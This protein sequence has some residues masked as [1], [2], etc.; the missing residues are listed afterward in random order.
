MRTPCIDHGKK[1][2]TN[3]YL[4]RK[5]GGRNEYA[6]RWAYSL[7]TGVPIRALRGV[8]IRHTCDNARCIN[9]DHLVRGTHLDN[10]LD[11]VER[12]RNPKLPR[13]FTEAQRDAIRLRYQRGH[14]HNGMSAMARE[15]KASTAT[16]WRIIHGT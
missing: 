15:F 12:K 3:G 16:M 10:V 13:V 6:H 8:V 5:L 1:G 14:T 7:A 9:P 11:Q 4:R 2:T